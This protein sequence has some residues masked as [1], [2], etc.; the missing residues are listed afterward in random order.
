MTR[1]LVGFL[2]ASSVWAQTG[3]S[4]EGPVL[5]LVFDAQAGAVREL[6]GIPGAAKLSPPIH[7]GGALRSAVIAPNRN[8]AIALDR[9]GA[10]VLISP[11]SERRLPGAS[12]GAARL[13]VSPLGSAAVIYFQGAGTAEVFTG[14]PESPRLAQTLR[15]D[16]AVADLAVSDD[17][18]V[19]L[20]L[21]RSRRGDAAFTYTSDGSRAVVHRSRRIAA[22]ASVPGAHQVLV[23]EASE[24]KLIAPDLGREPAGSDPDG[25]IVSIA[26]FHDGSRV[27]I[28]SRSGRV[29]IYD[30]RTATSSSVTCACTPQVFSA[31]RGGAVFRLNEPGDGP[32]WLLD[33]QAPEPR[34][35]FVASEG[36]SR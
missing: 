33:T 6:T 29:T 22:I 7:N 5:G 28:G 4:I 2:A 10:A 32:V 1:I 36:D 35:Y 11:A 31:L 24:V 27:L 25:D 14:L 30:L 21:T 20:V 16:N 15:I 8:F 3:G 12:A 34:I 18:E 9:D 19:V 26:A 13:A 17:G 23:A